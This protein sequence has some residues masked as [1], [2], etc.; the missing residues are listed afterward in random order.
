MR[1]RGLQ[2]MVEKSFEVIKRVSIVEPLD[3]VLLAQESQTCFGTVDGEACGGELLLSNDDAQEWV[4]RKCGRVWGSEPD[5]ERIPFSDSDVSGGH[6]EGS[7]S[8]E[9]H[10]DW[11]GGLGSRVDR[12]VI[13]DVLGG[14][15]DPLAWTRANHTRISLAHP[16]VQ[17]FLSFGSQFMNKYDLHQRGNVNHMRFADQLGLDLR[18]I[19]KHYI[20]GLSKLWADPWL[21][22]AALFC[23]LYRDSYPERHA[24]LIDQKD[25]KERFPELVLSDETLNYYAK[26]LASVREWHL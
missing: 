7:Y 1:G 10:L 22:A 8:P 14:R 23:L 24:S 21:I 13:A 25:A 26:L 16:L 6:S 17:K 19:A 5:G 12:G 11:G 2:E 15:R 18:D 20:K 4:C 9:G 3:V